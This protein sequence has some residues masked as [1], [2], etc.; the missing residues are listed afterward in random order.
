MRGPQSVLRDASSF[1]ASEPSCSSPSRRAALQACVAAELSAPSSPRRS[2]L[3]G[4]TLRDPPSVVRRRARLTAVEPSAL[5]SPSRALPVGRPRG[6][7]Q[8]V[9]SWTHPASS[10][11]A[12]KPPS[13]H[14][15]APP[16]PRRG[17]CLQDPPIEPR[18]HI[19]SRSPSRPISGVLRV[20][21]RLHR[22][23]ASCSSFHALPSWAAIPSRRPSR[24]PSEVNRHDGSEC[25]VVGIMPG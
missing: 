14:H 7:L 20:R 17:V 21:V 19:T 18:A 25:Q 10:P 3:P 12:S 13:H 4:P 16:G 24:P 1:I 8:A 23:Q 6:V 5:K 2:A 11:Q 9:C 22:R 15:A